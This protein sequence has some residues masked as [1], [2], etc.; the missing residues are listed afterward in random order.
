MAFAPKIKVYTAAAILFTAAVST[1]CS[2]QERNDSPEKD[3][4]RAREEYLLQKR[5]GPAPAGARVKALQQLDRMLERDGQNFRQSSAAGQYT[6]SSSASASPETSIASNASSWTFIGPQVTQ[7]NFYGNTSGRVSAL[8]VDPT[9]ANVVYAGGAQGGVWKSI[10]GGANWLP[11][12]DDQASLAIGSLAIDPNNHNIIYAG[13]GEQNFSG[14]SYYGAGILKSTDG[15]TSWTLLS[16][17]STAIFDGSQG[18]GLGG[19]PSIGAMAVQPGVASGTPIVLAAVKTFTGSG[20]IYVSQDG[21]ASWAKATG[22][23]STQSANSVVYVSNTV[24]YAGIYANGVY[25][26]TDGGVTWNPANGNGSGGVVATASTQ[27]TMVGASPHNVNVVYATLSNSATGGNT[28]AGAYKSINGGLTWTKFDGVAPINGVAPNPGFTDFCAQQ[29]WYDQVVAV[30]PL[31]ETKVFFGGSAAGTAGRNAILYSGDGGATWASKG[32]VANFGCN[33]G[34]EIH[35]DHHAAAF[36]ANGAKL[37]WGSDGGVYSTTATN[38]VTSQSPAW[39]NLNT[40]IGITQF[41]TDFVIQSSDPSVTYAGAQDNGT[42]KF[43]NTLIWD[44]VTCGDGAGAVIDGNTPT[45]VYANCQNVDIRKS[46]TGNPSL[47]DFNSISS[48]I[49]DTSRVQFIPALIGDGAL[50]NPTRV[51]FGTFRMWMTADAG[52]TWNPIS[53]DLTSDVQNKATITNMAIAPANKDILYVGTNNGKVQK[54]TNATSGNSTTLATFTDITGTGL[55]TTRINALAVDPADAT[56]GTVYV[57]MPGFSAGNHVFKATGSSTAWT[58]ISGDLPNTPV[59]DIVVDPDLANTLYIGTDI[60]VF[61]TS[62][63]GTNWS[64]L[65]TGLP[66]VAV[67]GLE[68]HRGSRTLRAATH[69]RSMW[70]LNV[71]TVASVATLNVLPNVYFAS[72]MVGT[73]SAQQ[74]L[75]LTAKNGS[76]TGVTV[77]ATGNFA[78]SSNNCGTSIASSCNLG[79]TFSPSSLGSLTGTLTVTSNDP[80]SPK[81]INLNGVGRDLNVSF[82]RPDRPS[83]SSSFTSSA[84]QIG[85]S[86]TLQAS[87][88]SSVADGASIQLSC[89]TDHPQ[90]RCDVPGS[91]VLSSTH[92]TVPLVLSAMT[93]RSRQKLAGSHRVTFTAILDGVTRSVSMDVNLIARR[94]E[95][96]RRSH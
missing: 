1:F 14:D 86:Q 58:N 25:K 80:A 89:T 35:V 69:G 75:T 81:V 42:Q 23:P 29:C 12:T 93:S 34:T 63:G 95:R 53:G 27:R 65:G 46:T 76:L 4:P 66:R 84:F 56:G 43:S 6:G 20:G 36:S 21:G 17:Q 40:N 38:G 60:G 85:G 87:V 49:T 11:L 91:T 10:D 72:Q 41:Y 18:K 9:D 59:N 31:D 51:Y 2:A 73:T 30:N 90:L 78:I 57:V 13:T 15:G 79:I 92:Q 8:A 74:T 88:N 62:N 50:S 37:Y 64:L 16:S 54:S 94:S 55:P 48:P 68:L 45:T 39:A 77:S 71:P 47:F 82:V 7:G 26:S 32:C 28:L 22:M 3:D 33:A 67:F 5:G 61:K 96:L 19:F 52:A 83:R 24:A 44:D 70:D